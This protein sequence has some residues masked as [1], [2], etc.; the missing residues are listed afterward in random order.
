M[1]MRIIPLNRSSNAEDA[2]AT[3]ASQITDR[4]IEQVSQPF[5]RDIIL[6]L[7]RLHEIAPRGHTFGLVVGVPFEEAGADGINWTPP[8]TQERI[9]VSAGDLL[10]INHM[11]IWLMWTRSSATA[12]ATS[13]SERLYLRLASSAL[14]SLYKRYQVELLGGEELIRVVELAR[15]LRNLIREA[16]RERIQHFDKRAA[17]LR[18]ELDE[19]ALKRS[20]VLR[21]MNPFE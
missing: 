11:T 9:A 4:Q 14:Q 8:Y 15:S 2:L 12:W 18:A 3:D 7:Q 13:P 5:E 1:S 20:E 6:A 16:I 21:F 17:D 19:I 10:F